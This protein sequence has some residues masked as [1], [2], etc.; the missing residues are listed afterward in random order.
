[1][2]DE[3]NE[4]DDI[5]AK[6]EK[7]PKATRNIIIGAV[8]VVAAAVAAFFILSNTKDDHH[9]APIK[10]EVKDTVAQPKD[11]N[12][13]LDKII[14]DIKNSHGK[15]LNKKVA[16][17]QDEMIKQA[18]QEQQ[19]EEVQDH[20]ASPGVQKSTQMQKSAQNLAQVKKSA[21]E[22]ALKQDRLEK[23]AHKKTTEHKRIPEKKP[24]AKSAAKNGSPAT[25]GAY[26]QVGVFSKKPSKAFLSA[27]KNH[28]YRTMSVTINNKK[29]VKYLIGPFKNRSE[30]SDYK[31]KNGFY[32]SVF[33]EVK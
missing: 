6:E 8:I 31:A 20:I 19:I 5:F 22:T 27:L 14:Q 25:K 32:N 11:P 3:H 21:R 2:K 9:V 17:E 10:E 24:S 23:Q 30:A 12:A 13:E 15:D 18:P 33:F 7:K 16:V 4:F 28:K 1:M 26:L 29:L